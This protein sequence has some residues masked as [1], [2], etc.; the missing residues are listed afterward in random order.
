MDT[1]NPTAWSRRAT[2]HGIVVAALALIM[3]TTTVPRA[4][5]IGVLKINPRETKKF[6]YK[7]KVGQVIAIKVERGP[8]LPEGQ[9]GFE[10]GWDKQSLFCEGKHCSDAGGY[11]LFCP[12][13]G[14]ITGEFKNLTPSHFEVALQRV[15]CDGKD[16]GT[17][18]CP[19]QAILK[20]MCR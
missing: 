12:K 15:E 4:E 11:L 2:I 14:V 16:A 8:E 9:R 20:S 17:M 3:S 6:T 10:F 1:N 19:S 13:A 7:S 18:R 5:D